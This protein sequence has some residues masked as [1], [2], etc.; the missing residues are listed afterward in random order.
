M[1]KSSRGLKRTGYF[2]TGRQGCLP[3]SVQQVI[4]GKFPKSAKN[5]PCGSCSGDCDCPEGRESAE[6]D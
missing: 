5:G 1:K 6:C 2:K 3:R 4:A